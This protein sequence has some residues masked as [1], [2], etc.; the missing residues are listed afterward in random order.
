MK[1]KRVIAGL[2]ATAV[3]L[4]AIP[5]RAKADVSLYT[6][7]ED[8]ALIEF[9][10]NDR[11]YDKNGDGSIDSDEFEAITS[12]VIDGGAE[13]YVASLNGIEN[14]PNLK[15]L[16]A[17]NMTKLNTI[18]VTGCRNLESIVAYNSP[19]LS[20]LILDYH[21]N[22]KI[23]D[24]NSTQ[25]SQVNT[26]NCPQLYYLNVAASKVNHLY[27]ESDSMLGTVYKNSTPSADQYPIYNYLYV[28][29]VINPG[30][31]V[32]VGAPS[33]AASISTA[34]FPDAGF[35][36]Y[37]Y[38]TFDN[39]DGLLTAAEISL[40]KEIRFYGG[41]TVKGIEYFPELRHL[42]FGYA[43]NMNRVTSL[44]VTHNS[45][46]NYLDIMG[47]AISSLDLS[48]NPDLAYL[49]IADTNITSLDIRSNP[50]LSQAYKNPTYRD[51]DE[52]LNSD[53][54]TY[55]A[56]ANASCDLF[57]TIG[58]NVTAGATRVPPTQSSSGG[59]TDLTRSDVSAF[60]ERLYTIALGRSSD[61]TG[62]ANWVAAIRNGES[63]AEAAKGFLFS[64]EFLNKNMTNDEFVDILYRTFFDREA[65]IDGHEAWV[66]A[67]E[68]GES[69]QDVIMGFIN[70]TEWANVCLQYGI[71][72]GGTG[73][74][75]ITVEPSREV[76]EFATRL[77]TTCLKREPDQNGLMAWARQLANLKDTGSNAAH[78]FFFSDEMNRANV[79]NDEFVTRLY[80]TFMNR[81]PDEAGKNAWVN[82]LNSGVS[83]EEVFQGFA[84]SS[85]FGQICAQ[86]G[87]IR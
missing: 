62:K 26:V 54:Y 47:T 33:G 53:Y 70:S 28:S 29:L 66:A 78:G 67:L 51:T 7:L 80:L 63:G 27:F 45:K 4:P 48:H 65:D 22:L 37:V 55:Y 64:N 87:I 46:L 3:V 18:D 73:T 20:K 32:V 79:P 17:N 5:L 50:Y 15:N 2:L 6:I 19:T 39:G 68:R 69:K 76:I 61:S 58:C 36:R 77:Y 34:K 11:R 49:N 35:R 24:I 30:S 72:S 86:Y 16:E 52:Y 43:L 41:E 71:L 84:Q 82:Q 12:L 31:D 21:P 44:D 8:Q 75:S 13:N 83:R 42:E 81:M 85:E 57:I 38:D 23:I 10:E 14:F 25:I 56:D 1:I 59:Q 40:I 60:V 74:P 9:I